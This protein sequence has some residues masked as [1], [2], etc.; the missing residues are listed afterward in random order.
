M[1][2]TD[3]VVSFSEAVLNSPNF[4]EIEQLYDDEYLQKILVT[5]VNYLLN[6]ITDLIFDKQWL[7]DFLQNHPI[8]LDIYITDLIEGRAI[9][10]EARGKD[11]A[12]NIL[13]Y[14][15]DLPND[16]LNSLPSFMLGELVICHDV[17][18][19]Q[20]DEQ[21]K[22]LFN[23]LTHLLVHGILHLFGFDHELGQMQ[24]DEMEMIEIAIL[25]K[26][27]IANPYEIN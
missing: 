15:S 13:S 26:L 11:Y 24:Q 16:V 17:V 25:D 19:R 12:T 3:I 5:C 22:T 7:H 4:T 10:L 23:H 21:G 8:E 1:I 2:A 18:A 20:A 9:N 6:N 14:P 27:N